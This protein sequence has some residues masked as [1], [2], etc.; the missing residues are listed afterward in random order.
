MPLNRN[1]NLE[2]VY[3]TSPVLPTHA[4]F[5]DVGRRS[6]GMFSNSRLGRWGERD[7][8]GRLEI[9]REGGLSIITSISKWVTIK[10]GEQSTRH[11]LLLLHHAL[12]HGVCVPP[13]GDAKS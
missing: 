1:G 2:R 11:S 8:P 7:I 13:G 12:T 5:V 9:K 3:P 4:G 6:T 10:F